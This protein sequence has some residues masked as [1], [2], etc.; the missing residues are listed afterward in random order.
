MPQIKSDNYQKFAPFYDIL[1]FNLFSFM[2]IPYLDDMLVRLNFNGTHVL[3]MG[4]GTGDTAMWFSDKGY[5]VTGI[6]IS[7]AMLTEAKRKATEEGMK[8]TYLEKDMRKLTFKNEFDL[9]VCLFDSMNHILKE[10]E[11]SMVMKGAY[12]A[13]KKGGWFLFDMVTP[14]ELSQQWDD[15]VRRETSDKIELVLNST[16]DRKTRIATL[17][18]TFTDQS[19]KTPK[20]F[21]QSF[22]ERAYTPTQMN[23]IIKSS[24]LVLREQFKCFS[25]DPPKAQ[26]YRIFYALQKP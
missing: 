9:A 4:C 20:I 13:L 25:F 23:E 7:K 15:A 17:N 26:N 22:Q 18:G 2:I 11:L 8:I 21:T 10:E 6:D 24:G 3:D 1:G 19:G 12:H 14:Y 16:Y 5:E